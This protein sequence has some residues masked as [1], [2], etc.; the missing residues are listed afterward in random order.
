MG[1]DVDTSLGMG[2]DSDVDMGTDSGSLYELWHEIGITDAGG[3]LSNF[4]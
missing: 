3:S 4:W 2:M 1:K